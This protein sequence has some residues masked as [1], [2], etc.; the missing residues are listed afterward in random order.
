MELNVLA[1]QIAIMNDHKIMRVAYKRS[2]CNWI[3]P[4]GSR[5]TNNSYSACNSCTFNNKFYILCVKH[6]RER[7]S[8][9]DQLTLQGIR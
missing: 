3:K 1:W 2:Q 8:I 4:N 6:F 9:E 7:K 5:C